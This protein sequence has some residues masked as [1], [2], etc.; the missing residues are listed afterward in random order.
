MYHGNG[1]VFHIGLLDNALPA[2]AKQTDLMTGAAERAR[3]HGS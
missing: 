2:E 1:L 3:W